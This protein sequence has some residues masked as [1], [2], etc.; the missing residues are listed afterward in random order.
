[1]IR[2]RISHCPLEAV[3]HAD[4]QATWKLAQEFSKALEKGD[5]KA[6]AAL[7]TL[8]G[9]YYDDNRGERFRGRAG[10]E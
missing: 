1:V 7:Y 6:I 2:A 4:R 5:A 10:I 3:R 8:Q 9:E